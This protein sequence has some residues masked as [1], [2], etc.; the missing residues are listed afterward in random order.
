[1]S[2]VSTPWLILVIDFLVKQNP[3]LQPCC[4][5]LPSCLGLNTNFV[6][7]LISDITLLS[8]TTD[9]IDSRR[10]M[11]SENQY[12]R[13][14]WA[15]KSEQRKNRNRSVDGIARMQENTSIGRVQGRE[16]HGGKPDDGTTTS[17]GWVCR[18]RAATR[19]IS[20]T[21]LEML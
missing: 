16:W 9:H 3:L 7:F 5:I 6:I 11:K 15:T 2:W 17:C 4:N 10:E 13:L 21:K 20:N 12:W 1:M 18:E 14:Q 8:V 19:S